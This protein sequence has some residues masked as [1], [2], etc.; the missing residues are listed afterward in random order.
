LAGDSDSDGQL[1]KRVIELFRLAEERRAGGDSAEA[2][3][4]L[5]EVVFLSPQHDLAL[6]ALAD[7]HERSGRLAIAAQLR[8]RAKR[9]AL[10]EG[11]SQ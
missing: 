11:G 6:L 7:L 9:V 1:E 4:L 3:R 5:S 8:A 2:E 10:R